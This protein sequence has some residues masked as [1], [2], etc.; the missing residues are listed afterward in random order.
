[1]ELGFLDANVILRYLTKDHAE[2]SAAAQEVLQQ[3]ADGDLLVTTSETIIAEAVY[4]LSSRG[5]YNLSRP[6]IRRH[7]SN[8][9]R[10]Q[11]MILPAKQT[12][13]RAL[14][15]YASTSLDFEDALSIAHM[16]TL[17]ITT[18]LSFDRDFDRIPSINREEPRAKDAR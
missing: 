18:I 8:I 7:L 1:M 11:G 5:L 16:E 4:V 10:L 13:E 14:E 2:H 3:V 15:V 9:L 17:G 6:E 12:C